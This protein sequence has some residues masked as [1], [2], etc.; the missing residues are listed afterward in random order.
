VLN[1]TTAI[2]YLLLISQKIKLTTLVARFFVRVHV[3]ELEKMTDLSLDFHSL[4]IT[5]VTK[6]SKSEKVS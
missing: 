5:L 2:H 3:F 4:Y 1:T 6:V